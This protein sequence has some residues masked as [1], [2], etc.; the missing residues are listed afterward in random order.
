MQIRWRRCEVKSSV[1]EPDKPPQRSGSQ[2]KHEDKGKIDGKKHAASSL[3]SMPAPDEA[4]Q[5][6]RS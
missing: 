4:A 3:E 1:S 5:E 6:T 2:Q